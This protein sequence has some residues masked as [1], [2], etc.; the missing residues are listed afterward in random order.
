MILGNGE[1]FRYF[2]PEIVLIGTILAG[3][4]VIFTLGQ[5]LDP[6]NDL[7]ERFSSVMLV[8]ASSLGLQILLL[9]ITSWWGVS[10]FLIAAAGAFLTQG[11]GQ[12]AG[13]DVAEAGNAGSPENVLERAVRPLVRRLAEVVTDDDRARMDPGRLV[14]ARVD[15]VVA[16]VRA[17]EDDDLPGVAGIG[18]D[19]LVAGH[20]GVE[21]DLAADGLREGVGGAEPSG[22]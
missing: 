5:I 9:N 7:I 13:V 18:Q 4:G 10:G 3:V 17:G 16:D 22:G 1:S 21:D 12:R 19:L 15:P 20:P 8:A 14:L 11:D 2:L 6:I